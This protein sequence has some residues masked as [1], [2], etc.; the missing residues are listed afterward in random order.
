MKIVK[1]S[2]K[3]QEN[4]LNCVLIVGGV[5]LVVAL[6]HY[7]S[8]KSIISDNMQSKSMNMPASSGSAQSAGP[9][10]NMV[11]KPADPSV[12]DD[13]F[14]SVNSANNAPTMNVQALSNPSDLLPKDNNSE[15]ASMNP[16]TKGLEGQ[17]FLDPNQKI[18]MMSQSLRN[19]NQTLRSDPP[20]PQVQVGPFLN[21]TIEP[22]TNRRPLDI[23]PSSY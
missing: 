20:I 15:W 1:S 13:Q 19:A 8:N 4:L 14:S 5:L 18:G 23:G 3:F 11:I 9:S 2:K 17:T 10:N 16:A 12:M 6:Y 7:S 22:D 21:T